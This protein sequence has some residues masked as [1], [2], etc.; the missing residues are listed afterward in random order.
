MLY[1]PKLGVHEF[2]VTLGSCIREYDDPMAQGQ[3]SLSSQE[4][5]GAFCTTD[6]QT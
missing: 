2:F 3:C 1:S 6:C 5:E 4:E